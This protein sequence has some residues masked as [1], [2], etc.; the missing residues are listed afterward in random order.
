MCGLVLFYKRWANRQAG[1]APAVDQDL[2]YVRTCLS[3]VKAVQ[4]EYVYDA[5]ALS[6]LFK[7][8]S[9]RRT[10]GA[11]GLW[12]VPFEGANYT[13]VVVVA[14]SRDLGSC[15]PAC[16]KMNPTHPQRATPIHKPGTTYQAV[17]LVQPSRGPPL[18]TEGSSRSARPCS[19][20]ASTY[21]TSR[22]ALN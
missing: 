18:I 20:L 11:R 13:M 9:L 8:T 16:W 22:E 12:Y 19:H 21:I 17:T 14:N 5:P 7:L 1:N 2:A 10:P 4:D 15:Y 3:L 6:L